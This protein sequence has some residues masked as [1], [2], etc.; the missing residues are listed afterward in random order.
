M[1]NNNLEKQIFDSLAKSNHVLVA[2]PKGASGDA[3][4]AGLAAAQFLKK[5]EKQAEIVCAAL[6]LEAYRFL[7]GFGDIKRQLRVDQS[8]VI[9][10]KT[11]Q[12]KLDELS[13]E[14]KDDHLDIFLKPKSGKF[15]QGD[16]SF[17]SAR[18]PY[19]LILTLDTPSLEHLGTV[20]EANTDLF[21][22][23]PVVN[24]DHHPGNEHYGQIN[25]VDLT[26]TSTAEILAS[27]IENFE[28]SLID[29]DIAT[30]LLAGIIVETNSF[31]HVKTT[32]RAFLKASSLVSQGARQQ[33]IVRELYKTKQVSLLKLWG[34]ALAR[35]QEVSD[36]GLAYSM[37][38]EADLLKSGASTS[39]VLGVMKELVANLTG[40]KII[41]L[42]A[43]TKPQEVLGYF[44][45]HPTVKAQIVATTLGGQMLNGS[46][47][48]LT[49]AGKDLLEVEQEFLEKLTKIKEQITP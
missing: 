23:T 4:G 3:V 29:E 28:S 36:L 5:L 6:E 9:S 1:L 22:E 25:L 31:Q 15:S 18:F 21:F 45:L 11:E 26:A 41:L 24:I 14:V 43:E 38:N 19:D 7:P 34:R 48:F 44:Y 13:Y 8:F 30:N 37:V 27:L 17:K 20:Y 42:L 12:A 47:G 49:R 32:P 2:L 35:I 10:V 16:V 39:D 40:K 33:E 46:L